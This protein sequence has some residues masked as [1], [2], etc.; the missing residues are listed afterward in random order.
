LNYKLYITA[1][2]KGEAHKNLLVAQQNFD[3]QMIKLIF[4]G[5]IDG[6]GILD[7]IIDTSK[8]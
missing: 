4:A 2:I 1:T 8:N 7:L 5:D 3:D 6:D